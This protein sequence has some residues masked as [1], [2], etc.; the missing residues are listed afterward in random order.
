MQKPGC[1]LVR[2]S[3]DSFSCVIK[4][5]SAELW[6]RS[7][8]KQQTYF[9]G[10]RSQV[11]KELSFVHAFESASALELQQYVLLDDNIC[12]KFSNVMTSEPHGNRNLLI[13]IQLF[14]AQSNDH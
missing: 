12:S 4:Y 2:I 11:V 14:I 9:N 5:Q 7:K 10:C 1:G 13:Y 8:V 6:T 3:A